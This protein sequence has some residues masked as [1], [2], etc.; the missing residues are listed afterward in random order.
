MACQKPNMFDD[1]TDRAYTAEE[2]HWEKEAV[3]TKRSGE[4]WFKKGGQ[5]K[6]K[7]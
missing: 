1:A 5:S 7:R 3:N 2:V 4:S 6:D